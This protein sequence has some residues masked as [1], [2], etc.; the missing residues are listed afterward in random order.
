[1]RRGGPHGPPL[2]TAE[3]ATPFGRSARRTDRNGV[4]SV[5]TPAGNAK[6]F[7]RCPC[8]R[9]KWSNP[10]SEGSRILK[11]GLFWSK[12]LSEGNFEGANGAESRFPAAQPNAAIS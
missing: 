1:M 5:M 3:R 12:P 8:A 10:S 2:R 6:T 4:S 11:K 7:G 9:R